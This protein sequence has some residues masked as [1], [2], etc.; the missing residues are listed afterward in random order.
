VAPVDAHG[1]IERTTMT[2]TDGVLDR[3]RVVVGW[4]DELADGQIR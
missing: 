1:D 3:P 2:G 4:A